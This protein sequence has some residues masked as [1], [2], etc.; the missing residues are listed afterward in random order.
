MKKN[1]VKNDS[2]K[3]NNLMV[4][5]ATFIV[6]KRRAFYLIFALA[7]VLC[8]ISIPKVQVNN[9][10]SSYLPEETETRRGLTLMDDEF[11][12]Y[13]TEKIMVTTITTET[14]E[15]LKDKL[16]PYRLLRVLSKAPGYSRRSIH[17]FCMG[18]HGNSSFIVWSRIFIGGKPF[19]Q[20][21]RER[22]VLAEISLED[23]QTQVKK[24]GD[25]EIDGK[26]CTEF[27]IA[28]VAKMLISAIFHDQK[29]VWPC[30][31]LLR[32]EYGQH[33]VAAGVPCVIGKNGVE[34]KI[35][36]HCRNG[37]LSNASYLR[38]L[39]AHDNGFRN[40]QH[41]PSVSTV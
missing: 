6:D 20:L 15:K 33:D 30:S 11:I 41:A 13:D 9:D 19:L 25:I 37:T 14:A 4:K 36:Q 32:G 5:I 2:R 17:G 3:D 7:L 40:A 16:E 24:A 12:T 10:I 23:L 39:S 26:G 27:G 18:E 29:L 22:P 31:T 38:G 1:D 21:R 35:A 34:E 28:N 8:V